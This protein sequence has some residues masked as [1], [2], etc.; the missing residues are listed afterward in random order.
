MP[1]LDFAI[2][3]SSNQN[4]SMAAHKLLSK[5]GFNV[6]S[7][8]SG[9]HCKLPG[10]TPEEPNIYSFDSSYDEMYNDLTKKDKTLYTQNGIL[11]MLDRNR[12]I[13]TKPERFQD[14]TVKH[15]CVISCDERVYDQVIEDFENRGNV[16]GTPVHLINLNIMDNQEEATI[17]AVLICE[18]CQQI[19]ECEDLDDNIENIIKEFEDKNKRTLYYHVAFY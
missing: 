2:V 14:C 3:C 15:D 1:K 17:G 13:K 6:T 16:N 9:T 10:P 7:F 8:G 18:L 11:H 4:R 12:R 19:E 5:R